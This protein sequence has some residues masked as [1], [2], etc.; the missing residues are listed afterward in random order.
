VDEYTAALLGDYTLVHGADRHTLAPN[1]AGEG[2]LLVRPEQVRLGPA[3]ADKPIGTVQAVRFLG[4]YYEVEIQL[5]S[6]QLR[7]RT[8]EDAFVMGQTVSVRLAPDAT[9]LLPAPA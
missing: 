7:V 2:A 5:G 9:W 8:P 4:S 1:L 6:S 3:A